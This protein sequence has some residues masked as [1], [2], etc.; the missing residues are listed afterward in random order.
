[1]KRLLHRREQ[2]FEY[3]ARAELHFRR[4]LHAGGEMEFF[5][6]HLEALCYEI[7]QCA[8]LRRRRIVIASR[9]MRIGLYGIARIGPDVGHAAIDHPVFLKLVREDFHYDRLI[10]AHESGVFVL[11]PDFG[12]QLFFFG[13]QGHE[14]GT[15]GDD[16][17]FGVGAE[18][19]DDGGLGGFEFE[20]GV[21]VGLLGP[22]VFQPLILGEGLDA[23]L[24]KLLAIGRGDLRELLFRL[25]YAGLQTGDVVGL[26]AQVLFFFDAFTAFVGGLQLAGV[27]F[28]GELYV[29]LL[30]VLIHGQGLFELALYFTC[31]GEVFTCLFEQGLLLAYGILVGLAVGAVLRFRLQVEVGRVVGLLGEWLVGH[32][33]I[34]AA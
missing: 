9:L 12:L 31:G 30:V 13:H 3:G 21:F 27:A 33:R 24:L 5:A 18:V 23:F 4:D 1:M 32:L 15:G 19:F 29:G 7:D 6:V 8:V 14:H 28:F 34:A 25:S 16:G 22:V 17:A 2:V 20:Q 10:G 11:D 26:G